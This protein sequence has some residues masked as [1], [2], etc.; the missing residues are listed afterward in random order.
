VD[1]AGS[2]QAR[3]A[4]ADRGDPFALDRALRPDGDPRRRDGGSLDRDPRR[5]VPPERWTFLSFDDRDKVLTLELDRTVP[6][7]GYDRVAVGVDAPDAVAA[8]IDARR[9]AA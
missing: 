9:R 7:A 1:G 8:E 3:G 4:C 5:P 6:G 2:A